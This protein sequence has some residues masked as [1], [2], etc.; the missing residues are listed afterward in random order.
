MVAAARTHT[1]AARASAN[2][3]VVRPTASPR[4]TQAQ[5][6]RCRKRGD[7]RRQFEPDR[8]R[9]RREHAGERGI[10]RAQVRAYGE[11]ERPDQQHQLR[12]VVVDGAR[13]EMLQQRRRQGSEDQRQP[14]GGLAGQIVRKPRDP[15]EKQ[16]QQPDRP[17]GG[18]DPL[19]Q[20]R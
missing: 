14:G 16:E 10:A 4:T 18:G 20:R 12:I 13:P 5:R 8:E 11:R 9:K 7:R 2:A 3:A 1:V 19:R 6:D 15:N 17:D